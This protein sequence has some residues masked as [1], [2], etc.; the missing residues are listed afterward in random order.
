M[1]KS[2]RT[3]K[4]KLMSGEIGETAETDMAIDENGKPQNID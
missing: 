3:R 4:L 2:L 1:R